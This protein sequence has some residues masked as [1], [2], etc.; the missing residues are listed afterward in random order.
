[1][2]E[3][4][5][6]LKAT[7]I[8][9][10]IIYDLTPIKIVV[11]TVTDMYKDW[12]VT[13]KDLPTAKTTIT[14]LNKISKTLSDKRIEV[15]KSFKA[16]LD[17]FEQEIKE[18]CKTVD[19]KSQ[20]L[21]SQVEKFEEV[22]K[23]KLR[24]AIK[25]MVQYKPYIKFNERWLNKTAEMKEIL[26][27]IELQTTNHEMDREAIIVLCEKNNLE[28]HFYLNEFE[29]GSKDLQAISNEI[30]RDFNF[31]KS[32]GAPTIK[33]N[34]KTTPETKPILTAFGEALDESITTMKFAV[35]GKKYQLDA[36]KRY[37]IE[38]LNLTVLE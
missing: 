34:F 36:L 38:E 18:L 9:N 5:L 37:A 29:A 21:K 24:N 32:V 22:E 7:V 30:S 27:E 35:V 11:D 1:M 33:G 12:I 10:K 31:L 23:E 16:P 14:Q 26:A 8:P 17:T 19:K 13:D 2:D 28:P 15:A 20:D 6:D 4:S 25:S 3:L